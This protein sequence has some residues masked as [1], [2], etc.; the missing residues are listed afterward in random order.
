MLAAMVRQTDV[1]GLAYIVAAP[2]SSW[3]TATKPMCILITLHEWV[4]ALRLPLVSLLTA[5]YPLCLFCVF[6]VSGG[7][8][9]TVI[10]F[11]PEEQTGTGWTFGNCDASGLIHATG[12]ALHTMREYPKDFEVGRG[13][14]RRPA[15]NMC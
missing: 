4:A 7:L 14:R 15:H 5:H 1:S 10:D 3:F 6:V 12:L 2:D 8:G 13:A 11:N 9:D